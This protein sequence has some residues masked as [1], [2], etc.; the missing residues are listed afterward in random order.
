MIRQT[1]KQMMKSDAVH[2]VL[3]W[4]GARYIKLVLATGQMHSLLPAATQPY[5]SGNIPAIFVVWHSRMMLVCSHM[6]QGREMSSIVSSHTDGKMI[7]R[8][9]TH[10]QVNPVYGST[11]KGGAKALKQ[12]VQAYRLGENLSITPDGPRGPDRV[13]SEGVAQLAMLTQ[14][15]VICLA[16]SA[17]R[18]RRLH[19]WDRFMVALPWSRLYMVAADPLTVDMMR[20]EQSKHR[21][22]EQFRQSVEDALNNV[23]NEAD[24]LAGVL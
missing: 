14:A 12:L 18:H 11:S 1:F 7:G 17:A 10:F 22:R 23:T 4:C 13:A 15:P 16:Y 2:R 20:K 21:M 19:S 5:F 9:L 8:V 3:A 6:P 24:R